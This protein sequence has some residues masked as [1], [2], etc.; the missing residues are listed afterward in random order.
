MLRSFCVRARRC[1]AVPASP[2][3]RSKTERGLISMGSGVEGVLQQMV[4]R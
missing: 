4:F 1:A 2:N 3:I